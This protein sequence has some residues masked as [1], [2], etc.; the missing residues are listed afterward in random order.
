MLKLPRFL[1][2]ASLWL[3]LS[4]ISRAESLESK[5]FQQTPAGS[6][7][8]SPTLF[9]Q[10]GPTA[11]GIDYVHEIALWHRDKR[12]FHS[13]FACGTVLIGD[14]DG[15]DLS[16]IFVTGGP[17][18]NKL[19][20]NAGNLTFVDVSAGVPDV[21]GASKNGVDLWAGGGA[22]IDIDNDGDLDIYVCYYDQ[23]NHLYI[24]QFVET[25]RL[26][27][28]ENAAK[29]GLDLVDASLVPAFA[30]YDADG[31][32]D[33]YLLTHQLHRLGGR[34]AT[35]VNL[36]P[37]RSE[38][39]GLRVGGDLS[40][41][42]RVDK[43]D[44]RGRWLYSEKGRPD[45]LMRNDGGTFKDVTLDAGMSKKAGIG[46]SATWW[47]FN[48]DGFVDLHVGNDFLDPDYL[49]K[50]NGNGTFTDVLPE[51]FPQSTWF[52]MGTAVTDSN[53][54]GLSDFIVADMFPT[55]HYKQ[56][57]SMAS[58]GELSER[59]ANA[60]GARQIMRN[61]LFVNTGTDKFLEAAY[62]SGVGQTD[63]TWAIKTGDYDQDGRADLFFTNGAAR[64]FNHS[65]LPAI[66]HESL[67]GRNHWDLYENQPEKR[68]QNL[69]YRNTGNLEY[70]EVSRE[71]G[72]NH[73]GM[74]HTSAQGD[75]DNDGDLDLVTCS[76]NDP[77]Y[78]YRN[79]GAEGN[80]IRIRLKGTKSN[81]R[82]VGSTVWVT[83]DAGKQ[84]RQLQSAWGFLDS[85][86]PNLHFGLGEATTIDELVVRWPSGREQRFEDLAVNQ[87]YTITEAETATKPKT[88]KP[89]TWFVESDVFEGQRRRETKFNDFEA[90]P[91]LP[92]Q[93]SQL[94]PAQAWGDMDRDG[95]ED[96][97]M[98]SGAGHT[99][100]F[101]YNKTKSGSTPKFDA[102]MQPILR[103]HTDRE[104]MG[105]VFLDADADGDL[106]LYV[107]SGSVE[108]PAGSADYKDRLYLNKGWG[109]FT[110][111]SN[112]LPDIRENSS[113]V[114]TADF[115][116]DGD[117]DIFVGTRSVV[118]EYPKPAD[119]YLLINDGTGKFR[120]GTREVASGLIGTG[121]VT[122]GLWSDVD[123]DG[124]V[125][126]VVSHDWGPIKVFRNREG[127][128]ESPTPN[129]VQDVLGWWTGIAAADIDNDG[130]M[131]LVAS[132]LGTNSQY[133]ASA[134]SPELIF[135]GD[136]DGSGKAHIV[137]ANFENGVCYPRRG[138]SC[139]SHA[140]PIV[141]KK[142][143]TYH[144]FASASL[145]QIYPI[146]RL[147]KSTLMKANELRSGAFINDG[148]GNFKYQPLPHITQIAPGFGVVLEDFDLDGYV[149]CYIAQNHLTPQEE[150][151]PMRGGLSQLLR[152]NPKSKSTE[153]LFVPVSPRESGLIVDGDAKSVTA[154][155]LN[156]DRRLDLVV[157][158]NNSSPK[159]YL[160]RAASSKR[161]VPVRLKGL[162]GNA[163]AAGAR[164][165]AEIP[166]MPLQVGEVSL[167]SGFLSNSSSRFL[168]AKPEDYK[169]MVNFVI[170]WPDGTTEEQKFEANGEL[171]VIK[172]PEPPAEDEEETPEV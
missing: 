47:D 41:Y 158:I 95:L 27:F 132:N 140:M 131:D 69:A 108:S 6:V 50:N 141:K 64:V 11:T 143:Q 123:N 38:P 48:D 21:V 28:K 71:W 136:F 130:D 118:G 66:T 164:I 81:R 153:D 61:A 110:D 106:D 96:F 114:A 23:P 129:G 77:V 3:A 32:L 22:M 54:D 166:G 44:E 33:L 72:L 138:L 84:V 4:S 159:A 80:S 34:P 67:I 75:L 19:Y 124:W 18:S 25:G 115:D 20:V 151:G 99:G 137:E 155:D 119:S 139:S 93:L 150:T 146:D 82:G 53:N 107:A 169:G 92:F 103:T 145:S 39:T 87:F 167:G 88:S 42:Y 142:L 168:F 102:W 148:S 68:E 36:E 120:D 147:Q 85:D 1:L 170:R 70:E 89:E 26:G 7:S 127:H 8:F 126:L 162:K 121:L 135:Y 101:F 37:D 172:Q 122:G 83:T 117:L 56:K 63:W 16:D 156:R 109:Q 105:A 46:N 9:T 98:G 59:L 165:E 40:R 149:D 111:G 79:D 60:P 116:R 35:P 152:R 133:Q 161:A 45:Y 73:V 49:Y 43:K 12:L 157:G 13:S 128:L 29:F 160:N 52:T 154:M 104:D 125:D 86:E 65:D 94:G 14:I 91:L 58:M 78:I 163:D 90:Q 51:T 171:I 10:L 113:A 15:D 57:A 100:I 5:P 62:L 74:T 17:R 2:F 112:L 134:Q 24:N 30:D 97:W 76:L 55:T 144:N 31:D